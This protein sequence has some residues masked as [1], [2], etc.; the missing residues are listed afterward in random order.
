MNLGE[1]GA[2]IARARQEDDLS[3][4]RKIREQLSI[5]YSENGGLPTPSRFQELM[6]MEI[7]LYCATVETRRR[8]ACN[9]SC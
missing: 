9:G 4:L 2:D 5:P 6:K 3:G 7:E 8:I 1:V